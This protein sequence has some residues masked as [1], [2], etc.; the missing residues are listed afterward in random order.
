M[1]S[2]ITLSESARS[3]RLRLTNAYHRY[4]AIFPDQNFEGSGIIISVFVQGRGEKDS[5]MSYILVQ[6]KNWQDDALSSKRKNAAKA[7][8]T[9]SEDFLPKVDSYL[10]I[11]MSLRGDQARSAVEVIYPAPK[12]P[13]MSTTRQIGGSSPQE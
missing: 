3:P 7:A 5:K 2:S 11:F 9:T 13:D 10:G 6:V 12:D 4:A 8:F 1:S